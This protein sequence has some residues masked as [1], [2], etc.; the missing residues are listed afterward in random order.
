MNMCDRKELL[1]GFLYGELE[2]SDRRTFQQHLTT[3]AACRDE[4]SELRGTREQIALWTPPDAD[5]GFRIVRGA[6]A[7]APSRFRFTPGWAFAA[8]AVLVLAVGAAIAN[9]DVRYGSDGVVVRTGWNHAADRATQAPASAVANVDWKTQTEQID[10]RLRDLERAIPAHAQ[11]STVQNASVSDMT[12]AQVLQRVRDL[13]SQSEARQ[14][15]LFASR[16]SELTSELDARRQLDL[17]TIDQGLTRLQITS[18][19]ADRRNR[20]NI[21]R[22]MQVSAHQ[23]QQK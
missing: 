6:A 20:D 8:A 13:L 7:A 12:D 15:R 22:L 16:L 19:A 9:L 18:V 10:R 11:A 14:Q 3:C 21:N 17:A 2:P 4:L 23:T 5:L 1:V